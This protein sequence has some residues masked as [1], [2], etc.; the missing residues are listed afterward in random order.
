M[1]AREVW[2]RAPR[3][4]VNIYMLLPDFVLKDQNDQVSDLIASM[5][6]DGAERASARNSRDFLNT[7]KGSAAELRGNLDRAAR[8]VQVTDHRALKT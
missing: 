3:L 8:P 4:A 5:I 7:A 1:E 2:K 6:A